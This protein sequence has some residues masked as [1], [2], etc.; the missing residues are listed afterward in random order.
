VWRTLHDFGLYPF[1]IQTAHTLQPG[2]YIARVGNQP[3]HTNISFAD[4]IT[5]SRSGMTD[6]IHTSGHSTVV[7][8]PRKN[9]SSL[10]SV[11]I[12]CGMIES[13]I[14]GS[15]VLQEGYV[16]FLECE[17]SV[18]LDVLLHVRGELCLQKDSATPHFGSQ[19]TEFLNRNLQNR[20]IGRQGPITWPPRSPD[21]TP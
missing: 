17:L 1:H 15:F 13:Q 8:H 12:L 5:F 6:G 18:L 10:F 14:I 20:R 7:T 11:N 21:L 4:D 2:D 3:L 16:R 19:I 9:F